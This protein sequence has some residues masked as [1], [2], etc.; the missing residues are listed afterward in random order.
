MEEDEVLNHEEDE[1]DDDGEALG[2][3]LEYEYEPGISLANTTY[4]QAAGLVVQQTPQMMSSSDGGRLFGI[5]CKSDTIL[6]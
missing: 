5:Q 4:G 6:S 2:I 1:S 3:S